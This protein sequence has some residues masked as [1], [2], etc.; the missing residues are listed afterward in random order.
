MSFFFSFFATLLKI[1][2][3]LHFPP[4]MVAKKNEIDWRTTVETERVAPRM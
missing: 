3:V 4:S 1:P 2:L